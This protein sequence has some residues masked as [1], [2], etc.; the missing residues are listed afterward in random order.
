MK[1]YSNEIKE[2]VMIKKVVNGSANDEDKIASNNNM[3]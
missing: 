1:L 2:S 3:F